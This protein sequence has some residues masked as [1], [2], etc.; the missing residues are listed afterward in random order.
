MLVPAKPLLNTS[1]AMIKTEVYPAVPWN[2]FSFFSSGCDALVT[3]LAC[4]NVAKGSRVVLPALMCRSV[5]EKLLRHG[6][7]P[8]YLD[9]QPTSPMPFAESFL[10]SCSAEEV[11][12]VLLVDFFG[13]LPEGFEQM[14]GV[15]K[16]KGCVVVE[17]R[18]HSAFTS[19]ENETADAIIYSIR[20]SL[21]SFDGG[22]L[23]LANKELRGEV[24]P[25]AYPG[26]KDALFVA[27]RLI[28]RLVCAVGRPNIYASTIAS[29]RQE[30]NIPKN[31]DAKSEQIEEVISIP[32]SWILNRQLNNAKLVAQVIKKRRGNFLELAKRLTYMTPLFELSENKEVP[33]IFPFLDPSGGLVDYL[34]NRGVG[35]YRWPGTELPILVRERRDCFPNALRLNREVVCLPIHQSIE[36]HHIERMVSL[37]DHYMSAGG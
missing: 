1:P 4:L 18:C 2:Q 34:R 10:E 7:I 17:D 3:A 32:P 22:G 5:P 21:P 26:Y 11:G 20:K 15:L 19:A 23:W 25:A 28:E 12:A 35:A 27:V 16:T 13:F 8:H 14:V 31:Y 24:L 6:Y 30:Y 36:T 9:S 37:I 29:A 33:Q